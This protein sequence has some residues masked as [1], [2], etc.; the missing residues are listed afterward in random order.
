MIQANCRAQLTS[1]DFQFLV[2]TLARKSTDRSSLQTL[3]R[4]PSALDE[5]LDHD[6]VLDAL[7]NRRG[8]LH[9]S[10][11]LD[12][13]VIARRVLRNAGIEDRMVADYLGEM[14]KEFADTNR[15]HGLTSRPGQQF[16]Y[17]S[18]LLAIISEAR[19]EETFVVRAHIGNYTLFLTGVFPRSEERRVGKECRS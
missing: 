15:L 1:N 12:F 11:H 5:L 18:D 16:E 9:I 10:P 8:C 14:L 6:A 7:L 4:D 2:E 19:K 13:Y 3:I 17:I